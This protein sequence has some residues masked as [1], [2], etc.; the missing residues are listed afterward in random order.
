MEDI[1][2]NMFETTSEGGS[3]IKVIGVGGGGCNSVDHMYKL[4]IKD[5][6]FAVCNTDAQALNNSPV[7]IKI[8]LGKK[9][10]EG[11]GAGSDP[12]QGRLAAEES[13]NEVTSLLS[14]NTKMVFIT[15]GM[16]GG[17][18]TGATPVIA[19]AAKDMGIL[20]VAIVTIPFMCI[21]P[22]RISVAHEG[23]KELRKY[24]DSLLV[25]NNE[26]L[27]ALYGNL[28]FSE[29]F[30][31]ADEV[32]CTAAKGIAEIITLSGHV[33]VDFADVRTA[34]QNSGVSLMGTGRGSGSDRASIA[35]EQAINSP[36]LN[37]NSI[38]G[39]KNVLVNIV[40]GEN[41]L[42]LE[43]VSS[44]TRRV[45]EEA[46]DQIQVKTG[47]GKSVD[48]GDDVTVSIIAT[49]FEMTDIDIPNSDTVIARPIQ[50]TATSNASTNKDGV[51][52]HTIPD[53]P[54][55]S[56]NFDDDVAV[57]VT[58]STSANPTM[59]MGG[60]SKSE[61][62]KKNIPIWL[63]DSIPIEEKEKLNRSHMQQAKKRQDDEV[64]LFSL[65]KNNDGLSSS[66]A[67]YINGK[68]D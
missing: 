24:V 55:I 28:K 45:I 44:I 1:F 36:L 43:E 37:N 42:T 20:T 15:A 22:R 23:I 59:K 33:N 6:S 26:K 14:N 51:T 47:I 61:A 38:R 13:I 18:G 25:I 2:E 5:V 12:E 53:N 46:G 17:T 16:G 39:A 41:E 63:D 9:I 56:F 66:A 21:E 35:I 48:L 3:I 54:T 49:G 57:P 40:M 8:Q 7:P 11:L 27:I 31:K 60:S 10:T 58:D 4:G 29:A 34:M 19:K 50:K 30:A 62:R 52:V 65:N 68:P 67:A 32:V 64:S